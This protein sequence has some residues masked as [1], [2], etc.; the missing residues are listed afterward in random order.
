MIFGYFDHTGGWYRARPGFSVEQILP[1]MW[2]AKDVV[3][4]VVLYSDVARLRRAGEWR[5]AKEAIRWNFLHRTDD[6]ARYLDAAARNGNIRVLLQIPSDLADRWAT[7]REAMGTLLAEFVRRWRDEA[8]LAGFYLYDEPE[9]RGIAAETLQEMASIIKQE[10]RPGANTVAFSVAASAIARNKPLFEDY[11]HASP[12]AHDILIVNRYPIYRSYDRRGNSADTAFE[13]TKLGLSEATARRENLRDNE[14]ENLDDYYDSL[15][16]AK[17][18][19]RD[20]QAVYAAVQAYGLRDDCQG[21]ECTVVKEHKPRRSPTWGELLN[22][23]TSVWMSGTDGAILYSHY[24]ALYNPPLRARLRNMEDLFAKVLRHRPVQDSEISV[25]PAS[26]W[27]RLLGSAASVHAAYVPASD[28]SGHYHF[29]VLNTSS[30]RNVVE[31]RIDAPHH[32]DRIHELRFDA[33][34]AA[35]PP[36]MLPGTKEG[37]PD[38]RA[39]LELSGFEVR[40][41]ELQLS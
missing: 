30:K 7:D 20:H 12:P 38:P 21:R 29:V 28:R 10:A 39:Q 18:A 15:V 24:F 34:G 26:A 19:R 3:A 23:L 6:I 37:E 1:N 13:V 8:A 27:Q 22:L 5:D 31:L 41:F 36:A 14:F 32:L 17:D 25:Q 2:S 40:I 4:T 11:I 9:L 33:H 35:L 16:A